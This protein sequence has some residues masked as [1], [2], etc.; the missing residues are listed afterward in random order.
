M[1]KDLWVLNANLSILNFEVLTTEIVNYGY[2]TKKVNS[3]SIFNLRNV[4]LHQ[5]VYLHL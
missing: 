1:L 3:F 2:K 5:K 4:Y